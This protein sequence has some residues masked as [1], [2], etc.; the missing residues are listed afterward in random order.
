MLRITDTCQLSPASTSAR[1]EMGHPNPVKKEWDQQSLSLV[2]QPAKPQ[3][4]Q[5]VSLGVVAMG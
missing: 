5:S 3:T 1:L 2:Q 4:Q